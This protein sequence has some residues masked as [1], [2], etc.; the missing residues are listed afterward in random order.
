VTASAESQRQ[1]GE[2]VRP[3][4]PLPSEPETELGYARR[5]VHAYGDRLRY[6]LAWKRWLVWDGARWAHDETGQAARWMKSIARLVTSDALA[7]EDDR[8]RNAAVSAAERGESYR[9]LTKA[10]RLAAAEPGIVVTAAVGNAIL[11]HAEQRDGTA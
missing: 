4:D 3:A 5:L 1:A 8:E 11:S 7:I 6:V 10:L 2:P 9:W